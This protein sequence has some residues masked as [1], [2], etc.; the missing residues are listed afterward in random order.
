MIWSKVLIQLN[1][2]KF[3]KFIL[4][5]FNDQSEG[6]ILIAIPLIMALYILNPLPEL[7]HLRQL[8][9]TQLLQKI[10]LFKNSL[11]NINGFP[12]FS[13]KVLNFLY[14]HLIVVLKMSNLA[15]KINE[16]TS[17]PSSLSLQMKAA[18]NNSPS[19]FYLLN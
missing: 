6:L 11:K 4:L 2:H 12:K 19:I 13:S 14:Q 15:Q 17:L 10:L 16:S 1:I 3:L 18:R 9:D 5:S 7:F 8:T